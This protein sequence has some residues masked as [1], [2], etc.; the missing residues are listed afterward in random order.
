MKRARPFVFVFLI[1]TS[2]LACR[3]VARLLQADTPTPLPPTATPIPP[4]ATP[5]AASCPDEM[6]SIIDSNEKDYYLYSDFPLVNT[7]DQTDIPLVT[8]VV[9]GD[10]ISNPTLETVPR[11]LRRYQSDVST[12]QQ[13]WKLFA[14]LIPA[15]QRQI[16]GEYQVMTDGAG[17]LLA[18]VEQTHDDPNRWILEIDI[19][20]VPFTKS[21]VFTLLHEFG[22]LLTLNPSQVPPDLEI[23]NHPDSNRVFDRAAAACPYYFPGE[24]CSLPD[25]YVN[26]FFDRYWTDLY[27]EWHKIDLIEDGDAR[28]K[29]LD[30]F[31]NKYQ[32]QF[33]DSYAVTSPSED[34]AESWAFFI[35]SPKPA[36]DSIADQKILFFYEYPELIQ[37]RTQ[38]LHNLCAANP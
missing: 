2:T 7:G 5:E 17:E 3:A 34:I 22:H 20:D 6:A 15:D 11:T 9:N 23:F 21:L 28:Q 29:Q 38:I 26:V 27:E 13:A 25:S 8:Y 30:A 4:T 18:A 35:F 1:L 37:L 33:L 16:V 14:T 31:Y 36:G 12:Q 19:A 32:Q 24:G 10:Q